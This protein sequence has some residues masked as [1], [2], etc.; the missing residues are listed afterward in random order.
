MCFLAHQLLERRVASNIIVIDKELEL[1]IH[2]SGRNSGVL[3]AGLYYRP[4]SIKAKVC[5][6][7][8]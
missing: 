6:R 1:G 7:R 5:G 4:G 2:S 8:T 3:H